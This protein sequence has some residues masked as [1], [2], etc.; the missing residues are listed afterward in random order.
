MIIIKKLGH[1]SFTE[2]S[3]IL[4]TLSNQDFAGFNKIRLRRSLEK[5]K[6]MH[7]K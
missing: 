7:V 3:E 4:N 5:I 1:V 6:E 2:L